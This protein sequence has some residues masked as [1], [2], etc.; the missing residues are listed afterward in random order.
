[1]DLELVSRFDQWEGNDVS[2]LWLVSIMWSFVRV[3][4]CEP[5]ANP[6]HTMGYVY[7]LFASITS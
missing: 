3:H 2:T 1:M 4:L 6:M 5:K 7:C